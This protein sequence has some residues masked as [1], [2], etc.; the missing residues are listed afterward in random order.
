[1]GKAR[2]NVLV[3]YSHALLGL[4]LA[5][6]LEAER[7]LAVRAVDV[8]D[9]AGLEESLA[10]TPDVIVFEEG[11]RLEALE[12]MRRTECPVLIDI[13][14][15]TSDA[16]TIRRD[17]IRTQPDRL[18]E[19]ILGA[20]MGRAATSVP[21]PGAVAVRPDGPRPVPRSKPRVAQATS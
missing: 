6:L 21:S 4:G 8:N 20:C 12:L 9:Q 13:N 18:F 11:G 15:A 1:M 5:S 19:V 2:V 16:W 14:I 17:A 10:T 7:A 3:L